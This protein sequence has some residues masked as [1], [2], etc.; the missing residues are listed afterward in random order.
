MNFA[1]LAT[2]A[3]SFGCTLL[4]AKEAGY[5]SGFVL[6]RRDRSISRHGTLQQVSQALDRVEAAQEH[7]KSQAHRTCA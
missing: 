6:V 3:T 7:K 1:E 4:H 2:R 5:K